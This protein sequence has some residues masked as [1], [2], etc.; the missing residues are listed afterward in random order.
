M[1]VVISDKTWDLPEIGTTV[2]F[3]KT[4]GDKYIIRKSCIDHYR[5]DGKGIRGCF[6]CKI[7]DDNYFD[8]EI[9]G[10]CEGSGSLD[11]EVIKK[12]WEDFMHKPLN[13][14]ADQIEWC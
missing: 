3:L 8:V 14:T 13:K 12:R 2:Y 11:F 1:K 4:W 6:K 9:P 10:V 5:F 7:S